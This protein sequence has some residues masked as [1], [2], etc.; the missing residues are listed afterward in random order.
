MDRTLKAMAA[1]MLILVFALGCNKTEEPE[2]G[3]NNDVVLDGHEYV[4]LGL[5]SGTLWATC[6]LGA[7]T[8]EDYG[9]YY[10]WGEVVTK[11][12]YDWGSYRYGNYIDNRYE[13]NKYCTNKNWGIEGFVDSLIVLEPDD[14][15]VR[16]VWGTDWRMPSKED[17]DELYNNTTLTWATQNGVGGLL[18]TGKNGNTIFLPAT[19]SYLDG[20]F[21]NPD[22]G[23][24]W[25]NTLNIYSSERS[26]GLYFTS[27]NC[28]VCGSNDRNRGQCVRAVRVMK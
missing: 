15:V 18:V 21:I 12:V 6:N 16:A 24:Y 7:D 10:A 13:L 23:I 14:D 1:M 4:D 9:D 22:V 19:G 3:D 2:N 26:W 11:E 8:P 28:H 17:W 25:S 20:E 5:P 27:D